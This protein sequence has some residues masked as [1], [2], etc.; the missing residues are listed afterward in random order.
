MGAEISVIVFD[1]A[2]LRSLF[3]IWGVS[4]L[5]GVICGGIVSGIEA[6]QPMNLVQE[7]YIERGLSAL[8]H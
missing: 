4:R 5:V 1:S 8:P 7:K 6:A 3:L 2:M